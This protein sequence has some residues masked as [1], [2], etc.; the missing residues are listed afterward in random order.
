[1]NFTAIDFE[2]AKGHATPCAVGIVTVENGRIVNEYYTLIQPPYNEYS[3]YTIQ[4]HG[5]TPF[6]TRNAPVFTEVYPE[7]KKLLKNQIVVAHNVA[8]DRSVLQK[9]MLANDLDYSELNISENWHCTMKLC[10]ASN[11]YPSGKLNECCAVEGIEL[12]HHEALSD[13]KACAELFIRIK[14]ASS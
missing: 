9:T 6:D 10:K 7:I 14:S 8:F 12:N 3:P 5:I 4:V 11:R 2:T 1:M 13:A